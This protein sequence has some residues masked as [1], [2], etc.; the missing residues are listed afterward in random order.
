MF[1]KHKFD[2]DEFGDFNY[3]ESKIEIDNSSNSK[4]ILPWVEKF[5]PQLL[6]DIISN[7]NIVLSLKN[8]VKKK[9]LPHLLICGPSGTGK[10]SII[11]ACATELYGD[12]AGMMTLNINASEER[13]IEIIRNKVKDF[14]MTKSIFDDCV[15]FKL[16]IL[17]EAD[18][19]T[20]SAQSMLRRMIE[21]F[22]TNARFCLICN[23]L[24]NI[25]PAIQ[26]RCVLIRFGQLNNE[27]VYNKIEFICKNENIKYDKKGLELIIKI[28]KGDMRKNLNNLQTVYMAYKE[29]TYKYISQCLGYPHNN[30]IL[31]IYNILNTN[32]LNESFNKIYKIIYDNQ[33]LILDII[34]E[35]HIILI[36]ELNNN[37]INI[38]K[39]K[40]I[41]I[42]LKNLENNSLISN[43]EKIIIANFVSCFY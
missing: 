2:F 3:D 29:I 4:I 31:N 10:T 36:K 40:K 21:D 32:K 37:N 34:N 16:V 41:I 8:Y 30:D 23:K 18:A 13:G 22:T 1:S 14:V 15:D 42:K 33:Y 20:N 25:D 38:D 26:S 19:M 7:K 24:K 5:R 27:D 6:N 28:S 43:S 12:Y 11:N 39:F 35:I 17:D 9:Y